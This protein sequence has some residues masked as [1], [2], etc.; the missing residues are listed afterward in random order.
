LLPLAVVPPS[1]EC[2]RG[3]RQVIMATL[4]GK[5]CGPYLRPSTMKLMKR[6]YTNVRSSSFLPFWP[7]ALRVRSATCS[8]QPPEWAI[9]GHIDSFSQ[10]KIMGLEVIWDRLHPCDPTTSGRTLPIFWWECSQDL[11]SI[12]IVIQSCSVPNQRE[13]ET[14]CLDS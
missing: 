3:E 6:R 2:L 11:L 12:S 13:R 4:Q 9:L 14:P 5:S 10:C 7:A 1:G 8:Q